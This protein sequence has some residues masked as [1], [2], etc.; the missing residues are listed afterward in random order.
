MDDTGMARTPDVIAAADWTATP[1]YN[2]R[3]ATSR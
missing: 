3:V 2:I 1:A